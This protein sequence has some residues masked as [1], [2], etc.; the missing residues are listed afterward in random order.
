MIASSRKG[1]QATHLQALW[2]NLLRAPWSS[3]FTLNIN[4]PMNYWATS[5]CGLGELH[6]PYN[7]LLQNLSV[8][9]QSVAKEYYGANGFTSHHNTDIWAHANPV[10]ERRNKG[11]AHD[12]W[13][14]S[15][16]WLVTH[17]FTQYEY[18]QDKDFLK[19][20]AYPL[21]K[22][23]AEFFL[24]VLVTD[25]NGERIFAPSTSPENN[26]LIENDFYAVCKTSTMTT[27]IIKDL[28]EMLIKTCDILNIDADF[29]AKLMNEV[30]R[31]PKLKIGNDGRVLEWSEEL[32]E[33]D[34]T[35][36]HISHL[37]SLYPA[38]EITPEKT[39][40]LA[41][42]AKKSLNART[43]EGT[44]WS[45][46]WKICL[47]ARLYDSERAYKLLKGQLN[48]ISSSKTETEFTGGGTYANLLG[49]HPPFQI[50]GNFG[51]LAGMLEMIVQYKDNILSIFKAL[52]NDWK[53]GELNGLCVKNG[54]KLNIKWN[55]FDIN[56]LEIY[57]NEDKVIKLE[58]Q[59]Q[60]SEI[61]L[62]KGQNII[63]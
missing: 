46:A 52:P 4:L 27:S 3:N 19:E 9:G 11:A 58:I 36:R 37:Y 21:M 17:L 42:A 45:R 40:E 49:A 63:R 30:S 2:N 13:P 35:H 61:I 25:E 20:K 44:G 60:I 50:D 15:A 28:F 26:F 18:T 16:G 31:L 43:D 7:Q 24:D 47:W 8:T 38:N 33:W 55:N 12:F 10:G 34:R 48:L 5:A 53:T 54:L 29:S 14:L 22:K 62:K 56:S 6:E 23:A 57:S 39:I 41:E 32:P 59:N 1:T 51:V